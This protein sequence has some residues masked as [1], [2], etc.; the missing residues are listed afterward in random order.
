MLVK[1]VLLVVLILLHLLYVPLNR[2]TSRFNLKIRF[3]NQIPLLPWTVWIYALY[4]L[5]LP[6]SILILWSSP[7]LI[8]LL[9]TQIIS[10]ALA[11]FIWWIFP[12]GVLRPDLAQINTPSHRLLRQ[13]YFYDKDCNGLPSGHVMHTF[14]SC[15]FLAKF[16]PQ[17]WT[18]FVFVLLAISFSTLTTKQHYFLDTVTTLILAPLII[19]L[20]SFLVI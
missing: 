14:I 5:L 12:N 8:P 13:F 17:A 11:S 19:E 6:L 16:F 1:L 7:Y 18:L 3:D 20:S 15:F 2:R 9:F 10:T 4:Y